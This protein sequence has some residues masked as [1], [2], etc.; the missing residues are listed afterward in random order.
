MRFRGRQQRGNVAAEVALTLPVL[1]FI[2]L[3]LI[4]LGRG[5]AC[6]AALGYAA[7]AG[8]RYASV[9]STT[10]QDP[11]TLTKITNYVRDRVEGLDPS[12]VQVRA[13]LLAISKLPRN[14]VVLV[15]GHSNTVPMFLTRLGYSR[16]PQIPDGEFDN[17]FVVTPRATQPPAV[18][19]LRF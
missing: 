10:S 12:Q 4:D 1:L 15:V 13:T 14:A 17:L 6:K 11:A 7:R 3:G 2:M 5:L 19:R 9:R 18:V 8:T 16:A